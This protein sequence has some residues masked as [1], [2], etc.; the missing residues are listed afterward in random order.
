[1]RFIV[2]FLLLLASYA[3]YSQADESNFLSGQLT[4]RRLS[5]MPNQ[6]IVLL[7]VSGAT[8]A[9]TN[10]EGYFSMYI[11]SGTRIG[12]E[13]KF[14]INGTIVS[15][16]NFT[17]SEKAHF[18]AIRMPNDL[19]P[20]ASAY[21][22]QPFLLFVRDQKH[23]PI[24]GVDVQVGDKAY[25]TNN[26]GQFALDISIRGHTYQIEVVHT[27]SLGKPKVDLPVVPEFDKKKNQPRT[28][29]LLSPKMRF[30]N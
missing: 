13:S 26:Q 2:V 18:V 20:S 9:Y 16:K 7:D 24:K 27:D 23:R 21:V 5:P 28:L 17:F 29:P 30:I 22:R 14:L 11:P 19:L 10:T 1:M 8:P 4:D 3:A 15:S 25:I 6:K 12:T